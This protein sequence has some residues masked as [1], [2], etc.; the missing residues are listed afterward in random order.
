MKANGFEKFV[1]KIHFVFVFLGVSFLLNLLAT[2]QVTID[3]KTG[4][5]T[6]TRTPSRS[7]TS[8][9]QSKKLPNQ[10]PIAGPSQPQPNK[11]EELMPTDVGLYYH[12][13]EKWIAVATQ[14]TQ[15]NQ[16]KGVLSI[17]VSGMILWDGRG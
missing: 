6:D 14:Q 12:S 2:A 10:L 11:P 9:Q 15:R 7:T 1:R 3:I 13:G 17:W 8:P 16:G 5:V 4:N